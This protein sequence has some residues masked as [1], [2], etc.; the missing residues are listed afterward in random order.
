MKLTDYTEVG[1]CLFCKTKHW[2]PNFWIGLQKDGTFS[3]TPVVRLCG[4]PIPIPKKEQK[5][6]QEKTTR[7]RLSRWQPPKLLE[8]LMMNK[9]KAVNVIKVLTALKMKITFMSNQKD[10]IIEN[11][12]EVGGKDGKKTF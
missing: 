10:F 1:H 4:C 7:D 2:M 9:H 11:Q 12:F 3:A 5:E 8:H 6:P